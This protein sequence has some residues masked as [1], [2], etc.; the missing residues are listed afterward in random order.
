MP[1]WLIYNQKRRKTSM[2]QFI[3]TTLLFLMMSVTLQA[4]DNKGAK[5]SPEKFEADLQAFIIKEAGLTQ[6]EAA[7]FK[8]LYEEMRKKQLQL[9]DRM[10]KLGLDKPQDDKGCKE[11][12]RERDAIEFDQKRV[13]KTY[14]ERFLEVLPASKVYDLI[15][16]EDRFY[17]RMMR[18]WGQGQ[19][20]PRH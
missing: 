1:I 17:R 13:Q 10:R 9:F 18:G 6:Q 20:A 14:H 2:K 19:R 7:A 5:F 3:T 12:I 8:P 16:A 11:I 4:Q 15:K